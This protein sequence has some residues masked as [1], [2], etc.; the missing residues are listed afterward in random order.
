MTKIDLSIIIACYNE[1]PTFEESVDKI[2]SVLRTLRKRWEII[3]VEDKSI[4]ETRNTVEK[5]TR[6][7]NNSSLRQGF[8]GQA[9]AIFHKR[10]TGRG[11]SVS[12][13]IKITRGSICGYLDVDLEVSADYIPL[14]VNEIDKGFDVAVGKRFYE[15]NI[16]SFVRFIASKLYAFIVGN[17]LKIPIEDTEAGYKFFR[18]SR[19]L[20][21]LSRTRDKHWFWDTEI[22]A[23]SSWAGLSISQIPVL[24]IRRSD[25][26]STVRLIPDTLAYLNKIIKFKREVPRNF[27]NG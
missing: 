26:K 19:I 23:R 14:F 25:K 5:L 16:R 17:F 3:F 2:I 15:S 13:G 1:G 18:R 20:P 21:V 7:M 10:N 27:V 4:D 24:F 9:R 22:C 11:K 12:D 6:H 8:G